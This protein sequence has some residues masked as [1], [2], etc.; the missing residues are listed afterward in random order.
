MSL[1]TKVQHWQIE[2]LP[3]L[4]WHLRQ[5][6]A[7][8]NVV[9][10]G[11]QLIKFRWICYVLCDGL[12]GFIRRAGTHSI[13]AAEASLSLTVFPLTVF[14]PLTL[15]V[16]SPCFALQIIFHKENPGI[17]YEFYV[18]VEKK[19]LQRER[20]TE[21]EKEREAPRERQRER[22]PARAPLRSTS[23]ALLLSG[24]IFF[25]LAHFLTAMFS[26]CFIQ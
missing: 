8:P 21:R 26:A 10:I 1:L 24:F 15:S 25:C 20:L 9:A 23:L 4:H 12:Q 5:K 3:E 17:N 7:D 2:Q 11:L 16:L 13:H 19:V 14:L 18:P 6:I 22:E